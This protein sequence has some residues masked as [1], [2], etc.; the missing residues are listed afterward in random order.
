[1][2][3]I[4]E[5]HDLCTALFAEADKDRSIWE[6]VVRKVMPQLVSAA[7][8]EDNKGKSWEKRRICS[9]AHMDILKLASSGM[10][11]IYPMGHRWFRFAPWYKDRDA[12]SA[13]EA[14]EWY[15]NATDTAHA[16]IE[17]SNFYTEMSAASIDRC[18][19]GTALMLAELDPAEGMLVFTHVP[20]GTFGLGFD[21]QR[22]ISTVARKFLMTPAQLV[23]EFGWE[24]LTESMRHDFDR[25]EDRYTKER[26]IWHLVTPRYPMSEVPR[27]Y[28][29]AP[30]QRPYADIYMPADEPHILK[31]GGHHE[32][33][34]MATRFT[35]FGNQVFGSS[36]LLGISDTIDDLMAAND[37]VK[38]LGE[39]AA[40]PSVV[41]PADMEGEV[42]MRAGG[43]T[44]L[45]IQY[46]NANVPRE[47]APIG[48]YQIALDQVKRLEEEIDDAT[49]VSVLQII[50]NTD[51]YMTATEVTS[52]ESEKIM[53]FTSAFTQ[54]QADFRP[55]A[56]RIFALLV[57][58]GKIDMQ[59]APP[60]VLGARVYRGETQAYVVPP[61]LA[62]IGRMSQAMDRVQS[63]SA[64]AWMGSQLQIQSAT[65]DPMYT[66]IINAEAWS[67][68]E[69][70]KHGVDPR[71]LRSHAEVK[72]DME[73]LAARANQQQQAAMAVEQARAE[74]DLAGAENLRKQYQ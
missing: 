25:L 42:D 48:N 20:V 58:A 40:M 17:R 24:N 11:Y 61:Q 22:N 15:N 63:N 54:L 62:F 56:N 59:D 33:P 37:V 35:R 69:A 74:R 34:F 2:S 21:A 26:E 72:K 14:Q 1:M 65:Q 43:V 16:E 31:E 67:R 68:G 9:R 10:S 73:A 32:M 51:R 3:K 45:P 12:D 53:T 29:L 27:Q 8:L 60:E 66:A 70:E 41:L 4:R 18:A 19:T 39:R 5:Y 71:Y 55:M 64:M 50:S 7:N 23:E 6:P 52:R 46:I 47:F 30:E 44:L 28:D 36:P 13:M 38:L 57:R 49:Y